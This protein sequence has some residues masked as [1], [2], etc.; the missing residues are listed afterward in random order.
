[1]LMK[2]RERDYEKDHENK[3]VYSEVKSDVFNE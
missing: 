1:M 3:S 2:L